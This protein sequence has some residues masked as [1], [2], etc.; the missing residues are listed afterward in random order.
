MFFCVAVV[1]S[2]VAVVWPRTPSF[3]FFTQVPVLGTSNVVF[4]ILPA[5]AGN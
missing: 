4:N 2:A 5:N 1:A 3:R